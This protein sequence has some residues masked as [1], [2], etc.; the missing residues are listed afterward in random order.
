[1]LTSF[2]FPFSSSDRFLK[3]QQIHPNS[4]NLKLTT[5]LIYLLT[6]F[7]AFGKLVE[8]QLIHVPK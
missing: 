6:L 2:L 3:Q 4:N 5:I 1:M 7:K 8:K